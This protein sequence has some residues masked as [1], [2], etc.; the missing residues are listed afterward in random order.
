MGLGAGAGAGP[1]PQAPTWSRA[2]PEDSD[3]PSLPPPSRTS[4]TPPRRTPGSNLAVATTLGVKGKAGLQLLG[5]A[6]SGGVAGVALAALLVTAAPTSVRWLLGAALA[7]QFTL[8]ALL[9]AP[10]P[11]LHAAGGGAAAAGASAL[12][13]LLPGWVTAP[14]GVGAGV[15]AGAA[16]GGGGGLGAFVAALQSPALAWLWGAAAGAAVVALLAKLP[17]PPE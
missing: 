7:A 14:G 6:S 17:V 5:L 3:A 4:T 9:S 12:G 10:V 2:L 8:P 16:G 11:G 13:Q 15:G 1:N